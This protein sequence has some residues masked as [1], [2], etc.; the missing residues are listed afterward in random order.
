MD[1][2]GEEEERERRQGLLLGFCLRR[3]VGGGVLT[4]LERSEG[5]GGVV[6]AAG[7]FGA[8][9]F[10]MLILYPSEEAGPQLNTRVSS[11][12]GRSGL[13]QYISPPLYIT[14][15]WMVLFCLAEVSLRIILCADA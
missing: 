11:S 9:R 15:R 12:R 13:E 1:L 10:E 4:D 5:A 6:G 2:R 7:S 14:A 8:Y 3:R